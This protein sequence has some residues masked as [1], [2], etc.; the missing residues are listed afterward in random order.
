MIRAWF[1][2]YFDRPVV[3]L[4]RHFFTGLFD[5][6]FLSDNASS[7]TV[8]RLVAG[9]CGVLLAFGFIMTRVFFRRYGA[10]WD[11]RDAGPY[12]QAVLTDHV[13]TLAV[14]MWFVAF[15]SV[16]VGASVFPDESDFRILTTLPVKRRTIFIA[17]IL[18]VAGFS[19]IFMAGTQVALIPLLVLSGIGPWAER[20]FPISVAANLAAGVLGSLFA[21]LAVAATQAT[22]LLIVPR[23]RLL[24]VSAAAGSAMLFGLIVALP[25]VGHL[26][27]F[28]EAVA[29]N[30]RW[31]YVYPPA[32]FLGLERV[33]LGDARFVNLAA[34]AVGALALTGG[35]AAAAYLILY[36]HFDRVMV[37]PASLPRASSR[38]RRRWWPAVGR[39]P[40][41]AIRSFVAL[42]LRR[43]VFH[44]GV[45]VTIAAI[46]AAL[47]LGSLLS[48]NFHATTRWGRW[49]LL[50]AIT[51]APLVLIFVLSLAVRAALLAPIDGR[52]NWVFRVTEDPTLRAGQL[53]AGASAVR[54]IGV[55]LP[56]AVLFP[57]QWLAIGRDA[58]STSAITFLI[59][60]VFVEF[61][62]LGWRRLPFTCSYIVGKATAQQTVIVGLLVFLAFTELGATFARVFR[63]SPV[64]TVAAAGF[65][66]VALVGL[67]IFKRRLRG[68]EPLEFEDFVPSETNPLRLS[69]Y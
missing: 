31:L 34:A 13:F 38:P 57:I 8:Y 14:P 55:A 66:I 33:L 49:E 18:A 11:A 3:C 43:S 4:T 28:N 41:V 37:R 54:L 12:L 6:G 10:L 58:I 19:G 68:S 64:A 63:A 29:T 21:S 69:E 27:P 15:A 48:V 20:A 35:I 7:T 26:P 1:D 30:A 22:L 23:G 52:A 36:R 61:L 17:K 47:V 45:V 2:K 9:F 40:M 32:W 25:L 39:P 65:L 60:L 50:H 67:R 5:L 56:V 16:I 53:E 46:G 51:K 42:T 59:G 62:L 44:Q 24:T